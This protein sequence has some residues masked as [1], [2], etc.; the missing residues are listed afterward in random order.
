M[1]HLI[2][3]A[4]F[5]VV[6]A[7]CAVAGSSP[8]GDGADR[9]EA[10]PS[11]E[12]TD[13]TASPDP[14][15]PA[16]THEASTIDRTEEGFEFEWLVTEVDDSNRAELASTWRP[17]CPVAFAD[18]RLVELTHWNYSGE[19][20]RG[21]MV[22]H[23]DHVDDVRAVFARLYEARFPI[24]RMELIDAYDGDDD[25]SM[26]AN[27]SSAFNCREIAG[28][29]GVWSEHASG[30]AIDLNPL[31]NPWIRGTRVEPPGGEQFVDRDQDARGL[32]RAGD[33]VTDAFARVGWIWGGTWTASKDYQHFSWNGR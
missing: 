5:V 31:V 12:V 22:I 32:I 27:N 25:A 3:M 20:V 4:A 30:G 24:E 9:A 16:A 15:L 28:S 19:P 8:A 18:L 7:G 21:R 29:P 10:V 2:I 33:V 6:A 23:R 11:S 14:S 17:D 26:A 1:R 13:P